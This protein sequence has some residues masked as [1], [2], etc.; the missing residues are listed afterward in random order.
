MRRLL[1]TLLLAALLTTPCYAQGPLREAET[2]YSAGNFDAASQRVN[3]LLAKEATMTPAERA[4]LYLMKARLELA[5]GRTQE[6]KLWLTKARETDPSL[7]L[8]PVLDPPQLAQVWNEVKP[9]KP[10]PG[11]EQPFASMLLPLGAGHFIA[12]RGKDGGLFLA[13]ELLLL[14]SANVLTMADPLA[15]PDGDGRTSPQAREIFG[16]VS[17]FGAYGYELTDMLS[18][19]ELASPEGAGMMRSVLSIFPFGVAQ[20]KNGD[21][22]K[23]FGVATLHATLLTVGVLAPQDRQRRMALSA[24]GGTWLLSV[25][26]GMLNDDRPA[27]KS[28]VRLSPYFNRLA[29]AEWATGLHVTVTLP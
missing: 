21:T 15:D 9:P 5:Y 3:A 16:G 26:D 18:E 23:A 12:G 25:V 17:L 6:L 2:L 1:L 24:L 29:Q 27:K 14:L 22:Y 10:K 19:M 13:T 11:T 7:T 4:R 8:D 20:A 28:G